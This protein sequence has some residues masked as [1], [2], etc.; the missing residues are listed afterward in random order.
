MP[1]LLYTKESF[2]FMMLYA[3]GDSSNIINIL[4]LWYDFETK[5]C[6]PKCDTQLLHC[7]SLPTF[8]MF[9]PKQFHM[10]VLSQFSSYYSPLAWGRPLSDMYHVLIVYFSG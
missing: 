5:T 3:S 1:F 9:H 8:S 6:E 10:L 4:N 7:V 2:I